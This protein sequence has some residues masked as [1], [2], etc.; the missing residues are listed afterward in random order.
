[1]IKQERQKFYASLENPRDRGAWWAALYGVAQSRTRL[2]RL[3]SSSSSKALVIYRNSCIVMFQL[4]KDLVR[5]SVPQINE[6]HRK[7]RWSFCIFKE[8][9]VPNVSYCTWKVAVLNENHDWKHTEFLTFWFIGPQAYCW[10]WVFLYPSVSQCQPGHHFRDPKICLYSLNSPEHME[11][12]CLF[13]LMLDQTTLG[14][15][16]WR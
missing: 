8:W 14:F 10:H 4:E 7:R 12:L 5:F 13:S 15:P 6:A 2:K 3:S 16:R 1:M 11:R 9:C